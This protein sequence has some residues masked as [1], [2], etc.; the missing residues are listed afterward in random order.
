MSENNC[1]ELPDNMNY[2][3]IDLY[4]NNDSRNRSFY[5]TRT[6][7]GYHNDSLINNNTYRAHNLSDNLRERNRDSLI[8]V[9]TDRK[10]DRDQ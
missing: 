4:K 6:N 1:N 2:P 3:K 8:Q 10:Y 7:D 5:K 9:M